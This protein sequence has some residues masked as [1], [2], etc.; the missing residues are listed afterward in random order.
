MYQERWN[1]ASL[2]PDA[3][4]GGVQKPEE[5]AESEGVMGDRVEKYRRRSFATTAADSARDD[6]SLERSEVAFS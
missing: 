2:K 5:R 4:T 1:V 6:S 3:D